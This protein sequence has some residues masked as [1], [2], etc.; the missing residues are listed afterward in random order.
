MAEHSI[1]YR[2]YEKSVPD[3][4]D[5]T[6][7]IGGTDRDIETRMKEHFNQ[8][9]RHVIAGTAN[10][11]H[12]IVCELGQRFFEDYAIEDITEEFKTERAAISYYDTFY[13]NGNGWNMNTTGWGMRP[14]HSEET[15]KNIS[16]AMSG[17]THSEE[18]LLRMSAAQSGNKN[19][20]WIDIPNDD[21]LAT[22]EAHPEWPKAR[23]AR[24]VGYTGNCPSDFIRRRLERINKQH[25]DS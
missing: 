23:V 14:E 3:P 4:I 21:I 8:S 12:N 22:I 6:T 20:R 5:A 15:R 19:S 1:R 16:A 17:K 18:T 9:N 24:T 7:Y 25:A 10:L 13:K 11:R 2:I